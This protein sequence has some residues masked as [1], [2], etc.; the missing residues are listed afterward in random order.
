MSE[1]NLMPFPETKIVFD[2][3]SSQLEVTAPWLSLRFKVTDENSSRVANS[4]AALNASEKNQSEINWLLGHFSTFP[5]VNPEPRAAMSASISQQTLGTAFNLIAASSAHELQRTIS[6]KLEPLIPDFRW[7]AEQILNASK[8]AD[9]Q[10]DPN[11]VYAQ[12]R[13]FRLRAEKSE[14]AN[15]NW[16]QLME[17][18]LVRNEEEFFRIAKL[19]IRQTHYITLNCVP[20]L[21]PALQSFH[22]GAG[23]VTAF[24]AEE[25]GHDQLVLRSLR[26]LGVMT[27]D[28]I[29]LL[30]ET[31]LSIELLRF[32]AEVCPLGF[33]CLVGIFEG[34]TYSA[35]DPL[36]I[37]LE[38]SSKPKAANGIQT[39][40]MINREH[41]HSN[42]GGEMADKLG[43]VTRDHALAAIRLSELTVE[44]GNLLSQKLVSKVSKALGT[45]DVAG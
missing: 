24:I 11:T 18:L 39:H 36:A 6:P 9:D 35:K 15:V 5:L 45:Q 4:V 32:A 41:N 23:E 33:C 44:V 1:A 34:T 30:D 31:K 19:S 14:T 29:E 2:P 22:E 25:R 40:F 20:S 21:S 8:I 13:R 42:V 17:E 12:C 37:L 27:P 28:E 10:Y 16:Y 43:F 26:A 3:T 38:K 7:D